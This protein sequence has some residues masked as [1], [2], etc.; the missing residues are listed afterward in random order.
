M[1]RPPLHDWNVLTKAAVFLG[2]LPTEAQDSTLS[3][4]LRTAIFLSLAAVLVF[5]GT[6]ERKPEYL[7]WFT[8]K[9]QPSQSIFGLPG[10]ST[11]PVS[12]V[13]AVVTERLLTRCS[14]L[15]KGWVEYWKDCSGGR[16]LG[17]G[18]NS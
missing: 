3:L 15:W 17:F 13:T 8:A 18:D 7:S 10:F 2:R 11:I 14:K 16:Q 9:S 6:V 12:S 4:Y 1:P 5:G